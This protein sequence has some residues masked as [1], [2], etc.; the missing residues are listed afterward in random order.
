MSAAGTVY[1][2]T[3][4]GHGSDLHGFWVSVALE[5]D[6]DGLLHHT[7]LLDGAEF[8]FVV[9]VEGALKAGATVRLYLAPRPSPVAE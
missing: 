7:V 2:F 5:R 4:T 8:A 1:P 3:V 6:Y 9:R